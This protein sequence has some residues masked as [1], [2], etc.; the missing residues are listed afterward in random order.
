MNIYYELHFPTSYV[1]A[2]CAGDDA[3]ICASRQYL[4][5]TTWFPKGFSE[6]MATKAEV[7]T[8]TIMSNR[9][10]QGVAPI[11]AHRPRRTL[12]LEMKN[13]RF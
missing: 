2:N 3:L 1:E 13:G 11:F 5:F 9:I 6:K 10:G 4:S 7:K 8:W 12:I